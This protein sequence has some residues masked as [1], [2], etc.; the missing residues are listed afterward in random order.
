[1]SIRLGQAEAI[2]ELH[3]GV[4]DAVLGSIAEQFEQR[5]H[6]LLVAG[7]RH[8]RG[9]VARRTIAAVVGAWTRSVSRRNQIV[10]VRIS[11]PEHRGEQLAWPLL[12]FSANIAAAWACSGVSS[13]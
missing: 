4:P 10:C 6:K 13:T 12:R 2:S 7:N 1:M 5:T 11:N 3:V 8:E 9:I